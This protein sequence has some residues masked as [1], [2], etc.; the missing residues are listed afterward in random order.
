MPD[1]VQGLLK[2]ALV[3]PEDQR[4]E[5]A[6]ELIASVDGPVDSDW[7]SQWLA[8]LDRRVERAHSEGDRGRP[9]SETRAKILARLRHG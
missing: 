2:G 1:T 4:L 6:S 5:L 7:E 9:W 8:E 3:L